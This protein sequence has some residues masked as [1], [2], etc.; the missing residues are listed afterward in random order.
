MTLKPLRVL[1]FLSLII[2]LLIVG[3]KLPN[4]EKLLN[5]Q[6]LNGDDV[7]HN[8]PGLNTPVIDI[9]ISVG[10]DGCVVLK[11]RWQA[12]HDKTDLLKTRGLVFEFDNSGDA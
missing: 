10:S 3:A 12:C 9:F 11:Y 5:E 7:F 6:R 4:V 2:F 8:F 1:L